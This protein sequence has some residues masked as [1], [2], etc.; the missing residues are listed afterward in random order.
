MP[1][2]VCSLGR[3]SGIAR[4]DTRS[5]HR[6]RVALAVIHLNSVAVVDRVSDMLVMDN[7]EVRGRE[8]QRYGIR[9]GAAR[10]R[11]DVNRGCARPFSHEANFALNVPQF[12]G[13]SSPS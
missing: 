13:P 4:V 1:L 7:A 5:P 9:R 2:T 6:Q 12:A 8:I 10:R 3:E 11:D